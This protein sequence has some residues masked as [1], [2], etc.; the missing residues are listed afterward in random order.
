MEVSEKP[1]VPFSY[2][3]VQQNGWEEIILRDEVT[4]FTATV[5]PSAGAL[6][7]KLE[8]VVGDD[9]DKRL[10]NV[11]DGVNDKDDFDINFTKAGFKGAKLSPFVCRLNKGVYEW[12]GQNYHVGT[13]GSDSCFYDDNQHA[14]HGLLYKAP[15]QII[16][17][18][19]K[20]DNVECH[21]F[22]RYN[23]TTAD[24][25]YPF[26]YDMNICYKLEGENK[27]A[28]ITTVH[29]RSG[30]TIPLSDGWHPYFRLGKSIDTSTLQFRLKKKVEFSS[31]L[32]PTGNIIDEA[33]WF[34]DGGTSLHNIQLDNCF[35]LMSEDDHNQSNKMQRQPSCILRDESLGLAVHIYPDLQAYPYLQLY[36]P[37]SRGSIAIENLSSAPDAFNNK[38]GLI[39]L[40]P[41]ATKTF[42]TCYQIITEK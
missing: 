27:L 9:H 35:I 21:L 33:T 40:E 2:T 1:C 23:G 38:M 13:T 6:L 26:A 22:Y 19:T 31:D 4:G 10:F 30:K 3:R 25:G 24:P 34:K 11:I 20:S 16:K 8:V 12:D 41:E 29:N 42:T 5:V 36:I 15:F 18:E 39:T 28:V 7:R 17:V 14:L 32:L 37:P